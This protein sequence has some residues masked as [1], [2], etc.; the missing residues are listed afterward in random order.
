M[1]LADVAQFGDKNYYS[2]KDAV[3]AIENGKSGTIKLLRES[4]NWDDL[5]VLNIVDKDVTIDMRGYTLKARLHVYGKNSRLILKNG[6]L[7][8]S[9]RPEI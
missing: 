4:K 7:D 5:D 9:Q 3:E 2:L 1:V 6:T 8:I